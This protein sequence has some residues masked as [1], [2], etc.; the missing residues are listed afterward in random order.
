MSALLVV[1]TPKPAPGAMRVPFTNT[2][3]RCE[4]RPRKL[5]VAVPFA[6]IE[7]P[8]LCSATTCGKLFNKSSVRTKPDF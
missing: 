3:V 7:V 6:L 8:P 2:K 4:P 5:T 1:A